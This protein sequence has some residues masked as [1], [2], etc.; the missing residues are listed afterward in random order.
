MLCSYGDT[1]LDTNEAG[2]FHPRQA[3]YV[4]TAKAPE[5]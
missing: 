4:N 5:T 1:T 3:P 2:A